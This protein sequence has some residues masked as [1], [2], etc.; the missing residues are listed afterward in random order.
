MKRSIALLLSLLMVLSM[1]TGCTNNAATTEARDTLAIGAYD[2]EWV[3]ADLIQSDT[4]YDL[5]MMMAE[6]LFL[7][8]HDTGELEGCLGTAPTFSEDGKTMTF[9]IPA[10]RKFANG[11]ELGADD[12]KA[13][14][15]YAKAEGAMKDTFSIIQQIDVDGNK[16]TLQLENYS[17]AVLI[18]LVSPFFCVIDTEQFATMSKEELLWGAQ[19]YGAYYIDT[20]VEGSSVTL[21]RNPY[22]QT[23]NPTIANKGPAGIETIQVNW[24]ADEFAGITAFQTGEI[25]FLINITEDGL[26]QCSKLDGVVTNSTL[27]PMVRNVQMNTS[28]PILQDKNVRLAIAYLIDRDQIADA[29]GGPVCC[30]P[31]YSYITKNVMFH[32]EE[33]D[34]WFKDT[35]CNDVE[36]GLALLQEAGW[37][38]S[39]GDKILDKNG[40][41]L[42]LTFNTATGKN[43]TAALAIQQQLQSYGFDINLQSMTS[44]LCNE[45]MKNKEY[46]LAMCNYWWSEPGR[47][48]VNMFKDHNDFDETEYRALVKEVETTT[49]N[50][51]RFRLVDEAQ[52]Y[53]MDEMI[54][55]P[56]YT[57]SYMKVYYEDIGKVKFI[58]D[59]LFTNDCK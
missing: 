42:S 59:G 14:L 21:K 27:P 26:E 13:S 17:T 10:G 54:V 46:S 22:F 34:K 48:L 15:E 4:F 40:Q 7:Y 20:Y 24:Y 49:D 33:T 12:V 19:P 16:I 41:K 47:F 36:K 32:V 45:K 2:E 56:L 52:R 29:F 25:Q 6:P 57:T 31:A 1:F 8:N 53:L 51:L 35:Y 3:G 18:L 5:Q 9:E 37:T 30:T 11:A 50:E 44:S 28:D 39:D 23:L 38:D 55:L 58:V 43:E